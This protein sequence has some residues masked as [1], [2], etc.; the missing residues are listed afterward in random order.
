MPQYTISVQG[1][2]YKTI[3]AENGYDLGTVNTI[4]SADI[5]NGVVRVDAGLPLN[6]TITPVPNT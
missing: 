2:V 6:I 5:A 3:T 1:N 4:I